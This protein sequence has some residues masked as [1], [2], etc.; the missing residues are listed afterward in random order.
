MCRCSTTPSGWRERS[1]R[2][3]RIL[4][5]RN[6]M[7][8]REPA[9]TRTGDPMK[10]LELRR[11]PGDRALYALETIGTLRLEGLFSSR[12]T[13]EAGG[14]SWRLGRR[15]LWG[16]LQALDT[17]GTVVGTFERRFAGGGTLRW[18]DRELTLRRA[19]VFR[20]RYA[21]A[22]GYDEIALLDAKGWGKRPVTISVDERGAL[23]AG[24]LLYAAFVVHTIA[25]DNAGTAAAGAATVAA[26]GS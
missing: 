13:A 15:G 9:P 4:R 26:A 6:R 16:K 17:A 24:L 22:D 8:A 11:T 19:S 20:E 3:P 7:A 1:S 10:N 23:D 12:A 25:R 5:P 2:R 18:G 21:L 14:R